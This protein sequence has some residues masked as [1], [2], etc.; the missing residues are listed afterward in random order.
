[1]FILTHGQ[2]WVFVCY[3]GVAGVEV[4]PHNFVEMSRSVDSDVN[5]DSKLY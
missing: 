1:M 3:L 5:L 2:V 4:M